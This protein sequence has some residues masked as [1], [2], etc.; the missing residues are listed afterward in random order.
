MWGKAVCP[1][2]CGEIVQGMIHG[3][4]FLVTCP[5]ALYTRVS[6]CLDGNID[7]FINHNDSDYTKAVQAVAKTLAY[8]GVRDLGAHIRIE[9][10]IPHG[11][12]LSSS[13]AD[14]TAACLAAAHALG[15]SISGDVIA[16][17]A[18]SIEPSDGIM[19]PGA[20]LFD[21][22]CGRWQKGLGPLPEMDVYIIDTGEPVDTCRFNDMKD[23]K[24]KNRYKEPAVKQAL[25]MVF[26]AFEKNNIKL[27]GNAMKISAA[28]HQSILFKPHL[29]EIIDIA[30]RYGA[31]GVNAAHSGSAIGVFFKRGNI[32][33]RSFW[34]ELRGIMFNCNLTYRVI[35]THTDNNGPGL[36]KNRSRA[37]RFYRTRI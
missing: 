1:A 7:R 19:Y 32:L 5:V 28:A 6:V 21:H 25:D 4:N 8:F 34:N 37:K 15:E 27:L 29:S 9:T 18:L 14:I 22:I 36:V 17:I 2:S 31:I 13:T 23:L 20:V 33:P 11:V 10:D 12:G 3:C 35:K 24:E 16:D 30:N 26:R